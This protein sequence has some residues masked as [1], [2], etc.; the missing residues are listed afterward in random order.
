[1][2]GPVPRTR[3]PVVGR[4]A[5]W[6]W[7]DLRLVPTTAC[8]WGT[9]LLAVRVPPAGAA[10]LAVTA[11][12]AAL[13]AAR[14]W[15]AVTAVLVAATA[16]IALA[17][18]AAAVR[19][20]AAEGSPLRSP[21]VVGRVV[22]VELRLSGDPGVL[23]GGVLSRVVSDATV[24]SLGGVGGSTRL[25]E[26]VLLFAPEA[27][28]AELLPGQPVRAQVSV[29]A[30][31]PGDTVVAVLSARGPPTTAGTVP[32]E[33]GAAHRLRTGL[34]EAA[35]RVLDPQAAGLL[36]GLAVGDTSAA[37]PV[38]EEDFRRAGLAH[39]T[40]VS[41]ANVAI[42]IAAVLWPLRR[43]AVDPRLQ[44]AVAL[45]ALLAFVVLVR[46]GASVVRAAAMGAVALWALA[47]G[48]PRAAVPTLAA[49]AG[50]LLLVDPALAAD[51]GFAL[52]VAAT[53]AIVLVGPSWSRALRTRGWPAPVADALAISAAAG[54]ATAP[55][56]AALD[57]SVSLVALPAN[58]L[59]APAVPAATVLGLAAALASVLPGPAADLLVWGAGWPV[60][61]LV[62]V[63]QRAAALPDATLDWPE[64]AAGA[65]VL[66]LLL[67]SGGLLLLL[68]PWWRRPALAALVALVLVGWPLR[69]LSVGWPPSEPVVV[70][71]DVGQGDALVV[72]TT[73]GAGV[74][75]DAGPD[76]GPVDRCLDRLGI[77]RLPL[78]L[79]SH[80]DADHVGG[81]AGALS[82]REVGTVATGT[83]APDDDH[84]GDLDELVRSVGARR[85]VLLPGDRRTVGPAAFEV[86]APERRRA[87]PGAEPNDLSMVVRL[88]VRDLRVLFTGDLGAE[89][90]QRLVRSGVDLAADVLKVPHHGSG[91]AD[92][93]FLAATG[94]GVALI[95]LGA[96][97][98]YGH[99]APR[100]LGWLRDAGIRVH[101]TDLEGDLAVT[102]SAGDWAVATAGAP[103]GSPAASALDTAAVASP[104][105]RRPRV[106]PCARAGPT[107]GTDLP[108]ARR[109]GG[110]GAAPLP[111]RRGGASR[112]DRA[113]PRRR[114]ARAGGRG[115]S[116]GSAR[117]RAGAV[118]V[119]RPP[120]R[121]GERRARGVRRAGRR[122]HRLHPV[123][124]PRSHARGGARRG[125]AQRGPAQGLP[126]R[127][128]R[129]R[130]V[131]QAQARGAI[132]LR[133]QRGASPRGPDQPRR[134][135]RAARRG[136]QRP[137]RPLR[138][139]RAAGLRL[140]G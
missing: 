127:R 111:G 71:C 79:L 8:L 117:R 120:P 11:A 44:A 106:T 10:L 112:R 126:C 131:P 96:D 132:G 41:G 37:D 55:L 122:A 84:A 35:A 50:A 128:G 123:A 116:T 129:R 77:D 56:V 130:R 14:R 28:W 33:Q 133:P 81:L 139:G 27:G 91:D 60:R 26:D 7:V 22:E 31:R 64:G 52:S 24:T 9:T 19:G 40:A 12:A 103:G 109:G 89:A 80:L 53:A 49:A 48:R 97:N 105:R 115:S 58:L 92:P 93:E 75:V 102:G 82:G 90:E 137:P 86:L 74:L 101:R 140:R 66:T 100:L 99:P 38:L 108:T 113:P 30:P 25:D 68:R 63:A 13:V 114:A 65:V 39:L 42:V 29:A 57:G 23:D 78:V 47:G 135:H 45:A 107:R 83:L 1:M 16:G 2:T 125:Q 54:L 121:G 95:S 119:R 94:A 69:R 73:A 21:G 3:A 59:A 70:A 134:G 88:T 61:W 18:G 136:R 20:W 118:A 87:V 62:S 43:R 76:V 138:R 124:G 46:P 4:W 6:T 17:A 36:P 85:T 72:P 67:T 110:G 98:T 32:W 34:V 15:R 51:A 104:G 5:R